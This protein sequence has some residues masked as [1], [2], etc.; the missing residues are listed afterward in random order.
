MTLSWFLLTSVRMTVV[1]APCYILVAMKKYSYITSMPTS[2]LY[3]IVH[4][5]QKM[6]GPAVIGIAIHHYHYRVLP[7]VEEGGEALGVT[8]TVEWAQQ[9][10]RI[11]TEGFMVLQTCGQNDHH[12]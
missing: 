7:T 2:N 10:G 5:T 8:W 12:R 9:K 1:Q 11:G 4:R 3:N 6:E